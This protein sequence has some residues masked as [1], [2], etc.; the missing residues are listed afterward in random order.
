M[1]R[2]EQLASYFIEEIHRILI[3]HILAV[4]VGGC[5]K[6]SSAV[7]IIDIAPV[8]PAVDNL[9]LGKLPQQPALLVNRQHLGIIASAAVLAHQK[10]VGIGIDIVFLVDCNMHH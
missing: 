9:V 1:R 4:I 8:Y 5:R 3:L 10:T 7:V 2:I 6:N